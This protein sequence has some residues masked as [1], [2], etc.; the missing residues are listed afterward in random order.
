MTHF[1]VV[2]EYMFLILLN[3]LNMN[4]DYDYHVGQNYKKN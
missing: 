2:D 4:Y 3:F 1:V